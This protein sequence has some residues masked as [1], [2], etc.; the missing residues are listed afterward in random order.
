MNQLTLQLEAVKQQAPQNE[1][2]Q[3]VT[4]ADIQQIVEERTGIPVG[5]LA[6][7]EQNQLRN[8]G[9]H[10]LPMLSVKR[11]PQIRL[12]VQFVVIVSDLIRLVDQLVASYLLDQP[13]L[14]RRKQPS[15]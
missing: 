13:V 1:R 5:E 3:Q 2:A 12:P 10:L 8:L 14:E 11:K 15:N 4:V 6:E 7:S 9:E